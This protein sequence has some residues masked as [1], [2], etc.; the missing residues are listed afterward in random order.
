MTKQI[1]ALL[2]HP[3][4]NANSFWN[5]SAACELVDAKYPASPL[6]LITVAALLPDNWTPRLVDR[7][8]EELTED[9]L[10]WADIVMIGAMLPQQLDALQTARWAQRRGKKVVMGGPDVTSSPDCYEIADFLVLGEAE[11]I[12][13]DFTTAFERGDEHGRFKAELFKVDVTKSPL[14]RFDLLK[15]SNYL[16]IGVQYSRGCPFTCEFCDII[17]LYGRKPRMKTNEQMLAELDRLY[18]SGYRGH[19]DFVDD[20]LIGNKKAVKLF[21]PELIKWQEKRRFPF[22]F[23]TEASI[24]LSDDRDLLDLMSKAGFFTVFVGIESSDEETLAAARKKQNTRRSIPES[25]DDIYKAGIS[26]VAG[27]IVGFDTEKGS[28]YGPTTELIHDTKIAVSMAGLLY[29]LNNTQLSRRL[30]KEQRLFSESHTMTEDATEAG[31]GDQCTAGLNFDTLRPRR[32]ILKDYRDIIETIYDRDNFVDR[33]K[34]MGEALEFHHA[35][36]FNWGVVRKD[37][38]LFLKLAWRVTTKRPDVR[39][40]FWSLIWHFL[41]KNPR[42]LK[43][44]VLYMTVYTHLGQFSKYVITEID[45]RIDVIDRNEALGERALTDRELMHGHFEGVEAAE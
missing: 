42:A 24:N 40:P 43:I 39:G 29:A 45:R 16:H 15:K 5:Y 28:V 36:R 1:N 34:R 9:D 30:E 23:S 27:F 26:V 4:F 3:K 33:V 6:G 13:Q 11:E 44:V 37:A 35:H 17:E 32:E 2:V 25:I 38:G 14:P 19:V 12:L 21:L 7:N 10:A 18:E 8:C 41:R 31:V 20:N 22:E